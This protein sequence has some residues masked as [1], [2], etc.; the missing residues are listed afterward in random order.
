[1]LKKL[2]QASAYVTGIAILYRQT[3]VIWLAFSLA[4]LLVTNLEQLVS[5]SSSSA[6]GGQAS[7]KNTGI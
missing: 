3:N 1:M 2:Y 4:C 7:S 5:K 6:T